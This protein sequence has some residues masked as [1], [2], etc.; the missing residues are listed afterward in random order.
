ICRTEDGP[1]FS[2]YYTLS[3][4]IFHGVLLLYDVSDSGAL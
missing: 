4:C 1:G 3:W 2:K